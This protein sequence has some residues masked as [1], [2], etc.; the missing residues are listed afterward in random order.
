MTFERFWPISAIFRGFSDGFNAFF[1]DSRLERRSF[2]PLT[3]S[4]CAKKRK[5]AQDFR[6]RQRVVQSASRRRFAALI[7]QG[8][9][10]S[11]VRDTPGRL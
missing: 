3:R 8:G 10:H 1:A 5:K 4:G 6:H 2:E 11:K 7:P 9:S